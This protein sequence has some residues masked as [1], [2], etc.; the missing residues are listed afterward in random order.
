[1]QYD[2]QLPP[3]ICCFPFLGVDRDRDRLR[4]GRVRC[5]GKA[6]GQRVEADVPA[7]HGKKIA[8]SQLQ[9]HEESAVAAYVNGP[10]IARRIDQ[11]KRPEWLIWP[12]FTIH[13][14][15]DEKVRCFR[16]E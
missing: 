13:K 15:T 9:L 2:I 14:E 10:V 12:N 8:L 16:K 3:P 1:L 11:Y 4:N 5:S 6:G 7:S